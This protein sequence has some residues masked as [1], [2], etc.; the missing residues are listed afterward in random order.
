MGWLA[1]ITLFLMLGLIGGMA[2]WVFAVE[3]A[4][5]AAASGPHPSGGDPAQ[6]ARAK[7][8][9]AEYRAALHILAGEAGVDW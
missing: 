2:E 7:A 3:R 6:R 5:V 1:Q 8:A 4:Y 9:A